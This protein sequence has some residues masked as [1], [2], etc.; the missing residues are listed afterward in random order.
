MSAIEQNFNPSLVD[1]KGKTQQDVFS[2]FFS[3]QPIPP[4]LFKKIILHHHYLVCVCYNI[5][6]MLQSILNGSAE[7]WQNCPIWKK[8]LTEAYLPLNDTDQ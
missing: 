3:F 1:V 7:I 6:I 2:H 4:P 5:T 8:T